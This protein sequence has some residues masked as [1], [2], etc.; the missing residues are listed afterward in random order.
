MVNMISPAIA[1]AVSLLLT[2]HPAAARGSHGMAHHVG[3]H[4]FGARGMA[5]ADRA[6]SSAGGRQANDAYVGA[7]S[8]KRERLLDTQIKSICRGC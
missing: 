8:D 5:S 7:T 3:N 6:P 4:G 1:I 2:L